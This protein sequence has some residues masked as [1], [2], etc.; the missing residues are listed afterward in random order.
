MRLLCRKSF[1]APLRLLISS[2]FAAEATC[3]HIRNKNNIKTLVIALDCCR[4]VINIH[5]FI[6][7]KC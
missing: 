5:I 7:Y 6:K 4:A 2:I 3:L 1:H